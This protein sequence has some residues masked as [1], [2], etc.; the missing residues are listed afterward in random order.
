MRPPPKKRTRMTPLSRIAPRAT[1]RRPAPRPL[2]ANPRMTSAP[3]AA[4]GAAGAAPAA[5][6]ESAGDAEEEASGVAASRTPEAGG[7]AVEP[8]AV[9]VDESRPGFMRPLEIALAV[10]VAVGLGAAL[11]LRRRTA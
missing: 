9:L 10:L 8:D 1:T 4:D 7:D 5:D 6:A 3:S 2:R 11:W